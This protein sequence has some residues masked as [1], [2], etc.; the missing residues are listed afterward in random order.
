MLKYSKENVSLYRKK[1]MNNISTLKEKTKIKKEY[2]RKKHLNILKNTLAILVFLMLFVLINNSNSFA[3]SKT[4]KDKKKTVEEKIKDSEAKKATIQKNIT[5]NLNDINDCQ[6]KIVEQELQISKLVSQEE[7]TEE[8]IAEK[9]KQL[10]KLKETIAEAEEM[11]KKRL[12]AIYQSGSV[13]T[14]EIL[15][16]SNSIMDFLSNYHMLQE[17]T[18]I[19]MEILSNASQSK[20]TA[21]ALEKEL[22]TKKKLLEQNR[23]KV[24]AAR[25]EE[26]RLI[27]QKESIAAN[28]TEQEKEVQA[29]IEKYNRE[30]AQVEAQIQAAIRREAQA[31]R[32]AGIQTKYSGGIMAWP[33]PSTSRI[34][35]Y[36]GFRKNPFTNVGTEMHTGIDIPS[37]TGTPIV[38]ANSGTVIH[39]GWYGGYGNSVLIDH[40]GGIT[41]LYAHGTGFPP[42]I[43]AGTKVSKGQTVMLM[44]STGW[45]TGP[46][47]HFEVRINGHHTNPMNYVS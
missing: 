18:K 27:K 5:Q 10:E 31:K 1:Q 16:D 24:E 20:A 45:S 11:S 30:K 9:T 38:A 26:K 7:E 37:A 14:L 39:A 25:A 6:Q 8:T 29:Q 43:R 46:H 22:E 47:L 40:G 34:S 42:G 15:F 12:V 19:D 41:T 33:V 13:S 28:L 32:K 35:S 3:T 17:L 2:I 36:Y 4:Y 44:G 23:K 21:E